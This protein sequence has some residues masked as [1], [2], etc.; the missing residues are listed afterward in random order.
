MPFVHTPFLHTLYNT[1]LTHPRTTHSLHT[2]ILHTLL[3]LPAMVENLSVEGFGIFFTFI[4][5]GAY[6]RIED[7]LKFLSPGR[8]L[9]VYSAGTSLYTNTPSQ[10]QHALSYQ[11]TLSMYVFFTVFHS[12]HSYLHPTSYHQAIYSTPYCINTRTS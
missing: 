11:Y 5:P 8:Q 1:L 10:Y 12:L 3:L 9:R 6:V 2:T 4:M 7:G